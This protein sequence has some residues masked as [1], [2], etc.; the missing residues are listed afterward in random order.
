MWYL[1][2]IRPYRTW[3][4]VIEGAVIT[5]TGDHRT[6]KALAKIR[7]SEGLRRLAV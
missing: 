1:L 3:R 5:F 4:N 7:E 6:E 2:K